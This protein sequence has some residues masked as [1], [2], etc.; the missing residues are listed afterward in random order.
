VRPRV[1][2]VID[3][4]ILHGFSPAERVAIGDSLSLELER[5]IT[6]QGFQAF[7]NVDT[8]V[9]KAAPVKLQANAKPKTV[10]S[11]VAQVVHAS[12]GSRGQ[13]GAK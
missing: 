11:Q 3:E 10:G 6:E 5:L 9:L 12:L 13:R 8:P 1:E 7:E 4:L 2:I